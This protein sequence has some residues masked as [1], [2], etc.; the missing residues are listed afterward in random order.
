MRPQPKY[1]CD[2]CGA[3]CI[4]LTI[5]VTEEDVR[6]EPK[7]IDAARHLYPLETISPEGLAELKKTGFYL[8]YGFEDH[9]RMLDDNGACSIYASRPRVCQ[10]FEPGNPLCQ[11]VRALAGLQTLEPVGGW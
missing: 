11:N 6:R 8:T 7:L 3:C 5:S 1:E 2:G 10:R 9:C 4:H